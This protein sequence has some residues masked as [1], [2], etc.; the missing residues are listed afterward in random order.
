MNNN[1]VNKISDTKN[2]QNK[3]FDNKIRNNYISIQEKY[4][5]SQPKVINERN[6]NI[7]QENIYPYKEKDNYRQIN[8]SNQ[9]NL[10]E[11][12][13]NFLNNNKDIRNQYSNIEKYNQK[14]NIT[15]YKINNF[16]YK[17][18]NQIHNQERND[19]QNKINKSPMNYL[20]SEISNMTINTKE[21]NID[22]N[23]DLGKRNITD[24]PQNYSNN[25]Q[26]KFQNDDFTRNNSNA[27][28]LNTIN[29]YNNL[30]NNNYI[31]PKIQLI[32]KGNMN[33]NY[34]LQ[35]FRT[36]KRII[37]SNVENINDDNNMDDNN[38]I[39]RNY[40]N[41][42]INNYN[43]YNSLGD[44]RLKYEEY[45]KNKINMNRS[46]SNF[47]SRKNINIIGENAPQVD[48]GDQEQDEQMN[49]YEY[50]KNIQRKF[51][52]GNEFNNI[53]KPNQYNNNVYKQQYIN[54]NDYY[55][56]N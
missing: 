45:K 25:Y 41:I 27:Y 55:G 39:N 28:E 2:I 47:Y 44:D 9:I 40:N 37:P 16:N 54:D 4:E 50:R 49:E 30:P 24:I 31:S 53:D 19:N 52:Y 56:S 12:Y 8:V 18:Q 48:I 10:N 14:E 43:F 15:N 21:K 5:Y 42:N 29:N 23:N 26:M 6:N 22:D 13:Q 1:N 46:S 51:N 11:R 20:K 34:Y 3:N 38:R 36:E 7:V 17:Y 32:N 33:D 35:K